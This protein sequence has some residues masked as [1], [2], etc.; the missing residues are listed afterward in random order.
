MNAKV[1]FVDDEPD[2]LAGYRRVLKQDF[3]LE[4]AS[5]GEAALAHVRDHGPYAVVVSDMQMPEMNGL[6]LLAK[7]REVSPQTIRVVLTGHADLEG[8]LAALNEDA[9][10]RFLTKPCQ[11][12]VLRRTLT[13]CLV[14]YRLLTAEQELLEN[15]LMGSIKV[16]TEVLGMANPAAFGRSLRINRYVRHMV[17]VLKL[18]A[19]WRYEA[20][21]MLSQLGCI[22]LEPELLEAAYSGQPLTPEEQ[23][24]FHLHPD[25]SSHLL[26]NIPRLEGIA[27]IVGQQFSSARADKE[28]SDS[29]QTGAVILHLAIAFDELKG[30]GRSDLQAVA[31]LLA[32]PEFDARIV[33]TL[34]T[35]PPI[36]AGMDTQRVE[37]GSLEP[38]MVLDQ[39]LRTSSGLLLA[40]KGQEIT[41]PLAVRIKNLRHRQ[42]PPE[43]VSV[44]VNRSAAAMAT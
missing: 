19:P 36:N 17:H 31:E 21:A 32:R 3:K 42:V 44:L 4:T 43:K 41:Y 16:L 12:D 10:F 27:W 13:T 28:I 34:A 39:E 7:V 25:V 2:V 1:L 38:G 35:L 15:T 24:C 14:Q 23:V 8:A 37:I 5:S 29:I 40:G 6:Q 26:A 20:A 30:Q 33:E 22:T 9:V 11:S 18:E